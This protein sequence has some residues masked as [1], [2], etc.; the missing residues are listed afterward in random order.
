M[1]N[2]N[3]QNVEHFLHMDKFPFKPKIKSNQNTRENTPWN[4]MLIQAWFISQELSWV[5]NFLPLWLKVKE[6][7]E[8]IIDMH[9]KKIWAYKINMAGIGSRENREKTWRDQTVDVLFKVP[10]RNGSHVFLNPTNEEIITPLMKQFISW[11]A[12]PLHVYQNNNKFRDEKRA[13]SWLMRGVEF[14]MNDMYWFY[15]NE[16]QEEEAYQKMTEIY[17]AIYD[18]LGIGKDT[19]PTLASWW[20]FSKK[21]SQERQTL[22]PTGEDEIYYSNNTEYRGA[23][24]LGINIEVQNDKH[25]NEKYNLDQFKKWKASEVWNFFHL[26]TKF[27]EQFKL[28]IPWTKKFINMACFWLWPTRTMWIIAEKQFIKNE[29]PNKNWSLIWPEN[30]SPYDYYVLTIW[31][32]QEVKEKTKEVLS[33]IEKQWKTAIIDTRNEWLWKRLTQAEMIWIPK[34]IIIGERELKNSGNIEIR[35]RTKKDIEKILRTNII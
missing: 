35:N 9:L 11:G 13:K 31:E 6:N 33:V 24:K 30:I 8:K 15:E 26:W 16:L 7:I 32:S 21:L 18:D 28:T 22:I 14:W 10:R 34:Q 29:N 5:F 20:T 25:I 12:L 3:L 2:L 4:N 17:R 27:T 23:N 1:N 19:Y